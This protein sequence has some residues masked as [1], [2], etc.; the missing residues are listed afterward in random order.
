MIRMAKTWQ[1]NTTF[2]KAVYHASSGIT[3]T[4]QT[5]GNFRRQLCVAL[6]V[7]VLAVVLSIDITQLALLLLA[8]S[9]VLALE[10][11]NTAIELLID[12]LHPKYHASFKIVKDT[13]AGMVLLVSLFTL[14]I[15]FLI[16][17]PPLWNI[18]VS[19]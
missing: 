9:L 3:H 17:L 6:L 11:G 14:F 16:F 5:Q 4:I 18:L 1:K 10:M 7:I 12:T 15:G 8:I 2:R 19:F 13:L